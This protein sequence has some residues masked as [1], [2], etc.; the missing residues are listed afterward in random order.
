LQKAY[1]TDVRSLVAQ[2][3][4]NSGGALD[5]IQL[6]RDLKIREH[7]I[8]ERGQKAVATGL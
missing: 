1:R 4:I 8:K 5:P 7:L 6:Y 3:R 2:G